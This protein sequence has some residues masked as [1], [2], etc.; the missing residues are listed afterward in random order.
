MFAGRRAFSTI[1]RS[2]LIWCHRNEIP[3]PPDTIVHHLPRDVSR[4]ISKGLEKNPEDRFQDF[5]MFLQALEVDQ[6]T[7]NDSKAADDEASMI[8]SVAPQGQGD[9]GEARGLPAFAYVILILLV[10]IGSVGAYIML[11]SVTP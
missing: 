7:S 4:A 1:D 2:E 10:A 8:T 3:Q 5:R 9:Q 6:K 11:T